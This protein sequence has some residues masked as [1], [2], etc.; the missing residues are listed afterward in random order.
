MLLGLV[1]TGSLVGLRDR[2]QFGLDQTRQEIEVFL[3][4]L[5][6]V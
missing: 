2:G 6:D 5:G 4:R 1:K 3:R